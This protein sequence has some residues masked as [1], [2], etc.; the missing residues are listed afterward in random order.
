M[1]KY[2]IVIPLSKESKNQNLQLRIALRSIQKYV[3]NLNNV[4]ILTEYLPQWVQNVRVMQI[5][6]SYTRNKDANLFKKLL[7]AVNN[8]QVLQHFIFLSDDQLFVAPYDPNISKTV[9]NRRGRSSFSKSNKKWCKRMVA[10]F[11]KLLQYD[12]QLDCNFDAHV[13]VTYT[14]KDFQVLQGIDYITEP[15][16]CIN[17][18]ICGLN[19]RQKGIQQ[20]LVKFTGQSQQQGCKFK[21]QYLDKLYVGYND[22]GFAVMKDQLINIFN[23]KSNYQKY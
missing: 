23:Q 10:T 14:K 15:G 4:W 5:P 20:S 11:D 1:Y 22:S 2:D 18:L 12:I 6:D 16:Y 21:Q 7:A 13:P 9:F 19:H 17:T 8:P 3:H